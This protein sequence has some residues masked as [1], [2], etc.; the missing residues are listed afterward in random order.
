[1][2]KKEREY[3]LAMRRIIQMLENLDASSPYKA[4]AL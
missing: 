3:I 4:G 1:M 2:T